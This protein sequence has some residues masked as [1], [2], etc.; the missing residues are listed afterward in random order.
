MSSA[1]AP[2]DNT[3]HNSQPLSG[4]SMQ[5]PVGPARVLRDVWC[6]R[7]NSGQASPSSLYCLSLFPGIVTGLANM[8]DKE[9]QCSLMP[10]TNC[11][12]S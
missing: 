3:P 8:A 9:D 10:L 12:T 6:Q 4:T 5:G 7:W 1:K 11:S 2:T